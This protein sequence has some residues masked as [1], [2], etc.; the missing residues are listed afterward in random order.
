MKIKAVKAFK[1]LDSRAQPTI[2]IT[3]KHKRDYFTSAAPSGA[4]TG[5]KEAESYRRNV[6]TSIKY[7]N[8]RM[9]ATLRGFKLRSFDDFEKLEDKTMNLYANP[10]IAL[11]FALL[12]A[13]ASSQR[14]EIYELVGSKAGQRASKSAIK[15]PA[16]LGKVIGGGAHA[17]AGT[18]GA[19]ATVAGDIQEYLFAPDAK[20]FSEA[21]FVNAEIHAFVGKQLAKLD[22]H[23]LGGRDAEGG[24]TTSLP[25]TEILKLCLEAK[26]Y[27][28]TKLNCH[29]KIGIDLAASQLYGRKKYGWTNYSDKKKVRVLTKNQHLDLL[30]DL[31]RTYQL[32]YVEDPF[33]ESDF[34]SFAE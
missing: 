20:N 31:M 28:S 4:S 1:V 26:Q 23:F 17:G 34:D 18:K 14:K 24:W 3:V 16:P 5:K 30:A 13:L 10:T 25:A 12:K 22:P 15:F 9:A 2:A 19:G 11:E 27:A 7:F 6:D 32:E 33:E 21:A 29:V 8:S